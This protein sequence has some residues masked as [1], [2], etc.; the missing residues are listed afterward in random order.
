MVST[1]WAYLDPMGRVQCLNAAFMAR[2]ADRAPGRRLVEFH[3]PIR[4]ATFK[5][6]TDC[7][8]LMPTRK[9]L[10]T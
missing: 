6:P 2:H 5:A 1:T 7:A 8:I 9:A 4:R 10:V 3:C